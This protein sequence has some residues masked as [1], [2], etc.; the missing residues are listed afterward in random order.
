VRINALR[1]LVG[2]GLTT[3]FLLP[4]PAISQ[5][6]PARF[7][8]RL[9]TAIPVSPTY[10]TAALAA[11]RWREIGPFRGGRSVA[12]AGSSKRPNEYYFGTTG[13]GVFKTTDGGITWAPVT[14]K[15]FGGTIGAIGISESN[16]EIVYVGAG[17]YPIRGNVSHGD[18]VWRTADAGKTWVSLGLA[19]TR[20]I[21]RVRV[22]PTNPDI[23]YVGAQGHVF[24]PNAER[25]VYK[26]TDGGK[27]WKK[28]LY[29]N[30]STGITDLVMDAKDPET[31]YA[32]FWQAW[33]TPWQLVSGG[34]G[35]GIFKSTDGGEHWTEITRN[36]GLPA[37]VIGNIGLAVSPV[38]PSHVWAIIEADSGGVFRSMDGGATWIRTNS[39]RRLR[40]RAWYYTR[41]FA[42]TKDENSV[43]V[44]NTGMYRSTDNGKTFRN[45]QV[46]HGDNH[47]L[48]VAP[49][50][51]QRMIESND[52]G[53]NV[54]FNGGKSWS[55][56][57]QATAQFYHVV[58]T[59]HF[60]YRVCGA[61]QDNSTL[62]G[63]SRKGGGIGISDWY[64][65]GGGESGYIAVRPDSPDVVFAGSYG[66]LLTH[67]DISTGFERDVNPWPNN[68][69]G[70][71]AAD[72][73]YRFQWTYP[74]I[75]SPHNPNRMYVGSSVIFQSDDGGQTYKTISPDLTR[76]DPRTLGSSGGPITKDQTSVEYYATVFTIAESPRTAGVIWA[77]S[78]DGLAHVTR[79]GGKTW[80]NVTPAGL[81]EW[82]RISMIEPS[83]FAAG[84]AYLAANRYQLDD[85]KPYLYKTNDYGA[86]WTPII[87][88]IPA[89]EFT[90]VVREDPERAGLLYTGTERGVWVTFDDGANWQTLRRN[91]PIVPVH[92][93][94]IKEGDLVAATHGR[95]FWILDDLSALRQMQPG[96]TRAPAHLFKPRKV[97]RAGFGGGGGTG[98]AGGHPSGA[99]P[100]SGG[101]VYYWLAQPRQVVTMDFLDPQGKVIRTFTSQQIPTVAADSI[102]ADSVRVARNDSLKKAGVAPDTTTRSEARGEET[103]PGDEPPPRRPPPPR[104]ANKAGLNMF[105][106]NLRYP[107]ASVFENMIFWAGGTSGPV[108]LP[109]TYTVRMNVAGQS[110]RQPLTV[111]KDP[112]SAASDAD[113]R[114]Q[115]D[116]LMRIYARTSQA[117]DAVKM[118]R[119]V[120]AQLAD[121]TKKM[122]ADKSAAFS[123]VAKSLTD[124]LSAVESEIYQV[125]NQSS[126]DPLNYPIRL[127]NKIA[128]LS[129]VVGG[130]DAKPT[131][132]SYTVFNDLSSQLDRQLSTIRGAL[133][134]LPAIN[135]SLKAA[136]LPPIVTSTE[137]IKVSPASPVASGSNDDEAEK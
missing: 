89:T 21:S 26:T 73:R 115:F 108:I 20:Q 32:A 13:G 70:H 110:Y 116:F 9:S 131:S 119:S 111:V 37:G 95:S 105:A 130:T 92:D 27:S 71:D 28:I 18:G 4:R 38:N 87:N 63:P 15:Y 135:A 136:G 129:G 54:S 5:N 52:G 34:A 121:R 7:P 48:W 86:S 107:D 97:Y 101:V 100:P 36:R 120:K 35:S 51:A 106:W 44:L 96:I 3:I 83:N 104:V 79:D 31:L 53:A 58:T 1:F 75:I 80:K 81:P 76:H 69:M 66:G 11:L 84:T 17:E 6:A 127:N 23:V 72:A 82:S 114:E 91:L 30:D 88:G 29:R 49:N 40:Q 103:P 77:G 137:E 46:P 50:D 33:R 41:I 65:V 93:L 112:R 55:E 8:G 123:S 42:D 126:Q 78:D 43:Y 25:G 60:P 85:M 132:Q 122:P 2:A 128:A 113:L 117:N 99:N 10:D 12:V 68:P 102:R 133:I 61:Q 67:K 90:R 124:R 19:D 134:I 109:G 98:A 59:N 118:I 14:D 94:A 39:D 125:K 62:C 22:H 57:D 16:P 47:D 45:I 64:D 74:I 24:G 56:Q